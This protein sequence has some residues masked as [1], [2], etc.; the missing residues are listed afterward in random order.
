[1]YS[2]ATPADFDGSVK[3]VCECFELIICK[4]KGIGAFSRI[5]TDAD[6]ERQAQKI[7]ENHD[8]CHLACGSHNIRCICDV[9]EMA[10]VLKVP[11]NRYEFQVLYGMAEP[12]RI[13]L[14]KVAKRVQLYCPCWP[15]PTP[16]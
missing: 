1:M 16:S 8:I 9:L 7:L 13:A 4:S 10:K 6:F 5:D 11:E 14:V 15:A 2:Q 3:A 12:V